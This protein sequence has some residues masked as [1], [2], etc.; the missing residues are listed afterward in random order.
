MMKFL[1]KS[2]GMPKFVAGNGALGSG[3]KPH[4]DTLTKDTRKIQSMILDNARL[5]QTDL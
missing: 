3:E 2:F 4:A 5:T 1:M